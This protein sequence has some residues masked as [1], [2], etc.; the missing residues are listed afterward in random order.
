MLISVKYPTGKKIRLAVICC[1]NDIPVT[2]KL[3]GHILA[4]AACHRC[5]KRAS[6]D[7]DGLRANYGGFDDMDNWFRIKDPREYHYNAII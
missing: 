6:G 3:Y 1:S 7:G 5:Y 2:R 4:K